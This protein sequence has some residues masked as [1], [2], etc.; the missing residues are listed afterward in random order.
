MTSCSKNIYSISFLFCQRYFV[1]FLYSIY[2]FQMEKRERLTIWTMLIV[3]LF[4]YY[5]IGSWGSH[6]MNISKSRKRQW[7]SWFTLNTVFS[8]CTCTFS[9]DTSILTF[10]FCVN[11]ENNEKRHLIIDLRV[12]RLRRTHKT[13]QSSFFTGKSIINIFSII[14]YF[15]HPFLLPLDISAVNSRSDLGQWFMTLT[16]NHQHQ[17]LRWYW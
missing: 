12:F 6:S 17:E 13:R 7:Q 3:L 14:V 4:P 9:L 1:K 5:R 2:F 8:I 16:Q 11:I 15:T 10:S